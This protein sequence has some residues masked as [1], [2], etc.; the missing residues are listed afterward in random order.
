MIILSSTANVEI[1]IGGISTKNA[2]ER[3]GCAMASLIVGTVKMKLTAT[4]W[5]ISSNAILAILP[6]TAIT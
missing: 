4:A 5:M 1:M 2:Y 3:I 6:K